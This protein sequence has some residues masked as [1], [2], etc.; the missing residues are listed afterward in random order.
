[1][2]LPLFAVAVASLSIDTGT[3]RSL[4]QDV[5]VEHQDDRGTFQDPSPRVRTKFRYWVPD[6]SADIEAIKDDIAAVARIG[7]GGVE[8]L[9]YYNYGDINPGI[10]DTDWAIYGWGSPAWSWYDPAD[11]RKQY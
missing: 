9:P 3:A 5:L 1:M 8:L 6:A 10:I 11:V 7:G 4:P 2:K